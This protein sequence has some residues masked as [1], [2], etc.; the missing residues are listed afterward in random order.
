MKLNK[1]FFVGIV[2]MGVVHGV[3]AGNLKPL[4]PYRNPT[5][6]GFNTNRTDTVITAMLAEFNGSHWVCDDN[7]A[8]FNVGTEQV[9][10][11][12]P[13][14]RSHG[15][16]FSVAI[17]NKNPNEYIV[18]SDGKNAMVSVNGGAGRNLCSVGK[19]NA[20]GILINSNGQFVGFPIE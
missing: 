15:V 7:D 18:Y 12:T 10:L 8:T 14:N 16:C 5:L 17:G 19:L 6:I 3:F 11:R 1:I 9:T 2:T 13:I 4:R 20:V